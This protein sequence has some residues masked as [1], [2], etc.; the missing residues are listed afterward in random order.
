MSASQSKIDEAKKLAVQQRQAAKRKVVVV[1]TVAA[2][3]A[4]AVFASIA[5]YV[6]REKDISAVSG[7]GQLTPSVVD[8]TDGI[9]VGP[10][11]IAGEGLGKGKVRVDLYLDPMCPVCG[12]FEYYEA[13]VLNALREDGTIDVYYHPMAGLDDKS[14]GTQYSSRASQAIVL[15][16][17][18]DPE[19]VIAFI[20]ALYDNQPE[21]YTP[22]LDDA[23][24]QELATSVGV[25][26]EVVAKIPDRPYMDWVGDATARSVDKGVR[27]YPTLMVD[28]VIQDPRSD[29]NAIN[30]SASETALH[31][32]LVKL[33]ESKS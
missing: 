21:E 26:E 31:D 16:A 15:V 2:V 22:G 4:I 13:D 29:P 1:W 3:L 33:A 11:G 30:W 7:D 8:E 28:G 23:Q 10:E 19:H 25:P 12:G 14:M 6:I 20:K 5:A 9:G 17:E 24:I 18:E 27:G 32:A